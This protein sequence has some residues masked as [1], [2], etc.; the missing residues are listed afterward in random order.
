[1][2]NLLLNSILKA[3]LTYQE[4]VQN[5]IE[6][7]ANANPEKLDEQE[8]EKLTNRKLNLHRV[9]R[10][11]KTYKV[12][13]DLAAEISKITEPQ[14]WMVLTESWCGDSAQII[15]HIYIMTKDNPNITLK[16]VLRDANSEIMDQFLTNGTRSIPVIAG[17]DKSG[18]EL[19]RWGPRPKAAVE[20][21][22]ELKAQGLEKHAWL[23]KLHLWYGR[24]RGQEIEKEFI[25]VI[26]GIGSL[27]EN[28]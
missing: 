15:P 18:N 28:A 13:R 10:I 9:S 6:E 7:V 24:N 17:F 25:D 22:K 2:G 12:S 23:E 3:G 26:K 16:L 4:Y 21:V 27:K 20:L 11:E 19:F 5:T 8:A 1:M 14:T